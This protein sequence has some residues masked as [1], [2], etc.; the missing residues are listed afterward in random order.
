MI[1]IQLQG[2]LGNHLF[3]YVACRSLAESKK[4]DFYIPRHFLG[5]IQLGFQ[6]DL[7][8]NLSYDTVFNEMGITKYNSDFYN[9]Q[10]KTLLNGF[11]QS[12]KYF[13]SS[14]EKIKL[15]FN[16]PQPDNSEEFLDKYGDYC[17]IHFRSYDYID[18]PYFLPKKYFENAKSEMRKMNRNIKFVVLTG[19]P[20]RNLSEYGDLAFA[21][22]YFEEEDIFIHD[23]NFDF[24]CLSHAKYL[25]LS[26][27]SFSWWTVYLNKVC[28]KVIGPHN[29]LNYNNFFGDVGIT[30]AESELSKITYIK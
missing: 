26:N 10:D 23:V 17:F 13:V 22:S 2:Y 30:P 8:K 24:Y 21:K 7:G 3:Q 19:P 18:T 15:W 1:G 28:E 5:N 12:E 16:Q 11:F 20:T 29:W 4:L 25:I 27:S 14:K 9:V 6:C